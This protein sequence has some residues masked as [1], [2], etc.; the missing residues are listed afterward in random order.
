VLE[1]EAVPKELTAA[2]HDLPSIEGGVYECNARYVRTL[3]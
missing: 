2:T 3:H 1:H